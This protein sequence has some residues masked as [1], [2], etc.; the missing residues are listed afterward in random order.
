ML[1]LHLSQRFDALDQKELGYG[2]SVFP[3]SKDR[4]LKI[5]ELKLANRYK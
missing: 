1:G 3:P 5:D 4:T 2:C